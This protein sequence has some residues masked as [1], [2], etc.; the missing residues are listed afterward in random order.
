MEVYDK[1]YRWELNPRLHT[2]RENNTSIIR[3]LMFPTGFEPVV[4]SSI[5]HSKGTMY[6]AGIE[7]TTTRL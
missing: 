1:W 5:R 3:D 2:P 6:H 7:P 4:S